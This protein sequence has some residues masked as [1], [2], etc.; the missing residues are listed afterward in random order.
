MTPPVAKKQY[1]N[2]AGVLGGS[3][4]KSP[5]NA[6]GIF[7]KPCS[8]TFGSWLHAFLGKTRATPKVKSYV[9]L[10]FRNLSP[11]HDHPLPPPGQKDYE[12][13]VKAYQEI[14]KLG[15]K[16]HWAGVHLNMARCY[17]KLGKTDEALENYR[18]FLQ[19]SPKS[20]STNS[21]LKKISIFEK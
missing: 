6:T 8:G 11:P 14:I 5:H 13:A 16:Y 10:P 18:A 9:T 15:E 4:G 21:I 2:R 12:K 17:E 1:R 3:A 19:I 7:P 20:L